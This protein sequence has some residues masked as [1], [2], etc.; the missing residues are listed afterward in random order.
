VLLVR[1]RQGTRKSR[2]VAILYK[3]TKNYFI[4]I[5]V[6]LRVSS[7]PAHCVDVF[8]CVSSR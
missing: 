4:V 6:L 2:T 7:N 8:P 5:L 3:Y 1:Y